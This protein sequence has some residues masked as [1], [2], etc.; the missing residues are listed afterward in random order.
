MV[1][2]KFRDLPQYYYRGYRRLRHSRKR[3]SSRRGADGTSTGNV[4]GLIPGINDV[5]A[6]WG[7]GAAGTD[8]VEAADL[9]GPLRWSEAAAFTLVSMP[10]RV[11]VEWYSRGGVERFELD[12]VLRHTSAWGEVFNVPPV[13][14]LKHWHVLSL[15]LSA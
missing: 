15:C 6:A 9:F 8:G 11:V 3:S 13:T 4:N 2:D 7:A 10:V 5:V 12:A 14:K 1:S